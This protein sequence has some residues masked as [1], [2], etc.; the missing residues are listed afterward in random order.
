MSATVEQPR[1]RNLEIFPVQSDGRRYICLR[2]PEGFAQQLMIVS[3]EAGVLLSCMD[4]SHSVSEIQA[5]FV[6]RFGQL[7]FSDRVTALIKALDE[8]LMLDSPR[9]RDYFEELR[10][11]FVDAPVRASSHAGTAYPAEPEVLLRRID[12]FFSHPEGPGSLPPDSAEG[13]GSGLRR[14]SAIVAP[15]IDL[16]RGGTTYA[17]AYHG[18]SRAEPVD[19]FIILGINHN[20]ANHLYSL[21]SKDYQTPLGIQRTNQD[22]V[23]FIRERCGDWIVE[24]EIAHRNEH[25]IE[26]QVAFLQHLFDRVAWGKENAQPEIVPVLC[27][28]FLHL[29]QPGQPAGA[30][31]ELASF[32]EALRDLVRGFNGNVCAIASVDLSHV[33]PRFGDRS[34]VS[35]IQMRALESQNLSLLHKVA[36]LDAEGFLAEI[37]EDDNRTRIDAVPAVY[38]MLTSLE[39]RKGQLL[40]YNQAAEE[41]GQSCVTFASLSFE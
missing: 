24:D 5:A 33:G 15:H 28:S 14:V 25:S 29:L 18:L 41:G 30:L 16:H 40:K 1:L 13:D 11:D 21:S 22:A 19:L 27:S 2:D 4:G 3:E 20:A 10:R 23:S 7:V 9:F 6:R 36:S 8:S 39:L 37:R 34:P 12:S 32:T 17:W 38:A 35:P 26:F 31:P